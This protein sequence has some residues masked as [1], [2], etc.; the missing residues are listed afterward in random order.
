MV[1]L[2]DALACYDVPRHNI[3]LLSIGC[4][5]SPYQVTAYQKY[6]G[7]IL[8]WLRIISVAMRFQSQ[9]AIGQAGLL[10]GA[11]RVI[12]IC[13][14]PYDKPIELDDWKRASVE[15]P[16][17]ANRCLEENGDTIASIFFTKPSIP[18]TPGEFPN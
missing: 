4:G 13:P 18:Y 3:S 14:A 2:V 11:N 9:N 6:S 5:D 1:A 7:G 10:V 12:R 16:F 8:A 15:L 17:V